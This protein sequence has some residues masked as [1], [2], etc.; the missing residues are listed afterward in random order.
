[1]GNDRDNINWKPLSFLPQLAYMIDGML[2]SAQDTYG[3][4]SQIKVHDDFT[5]QRVFEV[6]DQ[7]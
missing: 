6:T 2:E 4:L 1:M 3:P 5:I 7:H